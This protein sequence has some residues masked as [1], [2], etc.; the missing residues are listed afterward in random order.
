MKLQSVIAIGWI[1]R[2]IGIVLIVINTRLLV[3]LVGLEGLAAHAIVSSFTTWLALLNLG[4][5][6]GCQ[7]MASQWRSAGKS[8]NILR[9]TASNAT[10]FLSLA[11]LP[12]VILGSYLTH[13]Y[14]LNDYAFISPVALNI[15]F[16]SLFFAGMGNVYQ[17]LLHAEHR[18][19]WPNLYPGVTGGS[20]YI[21]LLALREYGV[22]DFNIIISTY[23]LPNLIFTVT[24]ILLLRVRIHFDFDW[25]VI[26]T[27]IK[28][29]KGFALI[30][31]MGAITLSTDYLILARLA[32]A[33]DVAAYS[34]TSKIFIVAQ[35]VYAVALNSAWTP[36]S[37]LYFSGRIKDARSKSLYLGGVGLLFSLSWSLVILFAYPQI[38]Q[39]LS[40]RTE[41]PVSQ[42]MILL[43]SIY[44]GLRVWSD[45]F[46]VVLQSFGDT[47]ALFR[48]MIIQAP[49]SVAL[50]IVLGLIFGMEGIL[51]GIT[52]S[53][54]I[55]CA[56]YLP[57]RTWTLTKSNMAKGISK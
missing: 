8:L 3:E 10:I 37:D 49:V 41:V 39:F 14:L 48:Y 40:P 9:E 11:L 12:L 20:V 15:A 27:L 2:A 21:L 38:L 54:V 19:V 1:A 30:A 24:M 42:N 52:I 46:F 45:S 16:C 34:L 29:A 43:W 7:K 36:L 53:F 57:L 55:T 51:L 23:F 18:S 31:T 32:S 26:R 35:S 28:E 22:H 5:P 44:L 33:E 50:Q 13:T 25:S 56:W 4:I 6:L 17:S 47:A